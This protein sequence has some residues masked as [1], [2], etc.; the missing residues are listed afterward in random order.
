MEDKD[1]G[2]TVDKD[3]GGQGKRN[4]ATQQNVADYGH[5]THTVR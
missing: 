4:E 1:V 5:M 3:V 2:R